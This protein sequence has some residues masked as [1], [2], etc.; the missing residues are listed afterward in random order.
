MRDSGWFPP[1]CDVLHPVDI[2]GLGVF[3]GPWA[4]RLVVGNN[5]QH[6]AEDSAQ[7]ASGSRFKNGMRPRG[8]YFFAR[9]AR[10]RVPM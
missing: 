1:A 2:G 3:R 4:C 6:C 10:L 8:H 5:G 7:R 9:P